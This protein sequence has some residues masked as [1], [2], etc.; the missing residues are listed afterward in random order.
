MVTGA[1]GLLDWQFYVGF[2]AD[3]RAQGIIDEPT[4]ARHYV[5]Q[6]RFQGRLARPVRILL[7]YVACGVCRR[8][9][10]YGPPIPTLS[11][12]EAKEGLA[13]QVP[14]H[15]DG[16]VRENWESGWHAGGL[17]NQLYSHIPALALARALGAEIVLYPFR[18][19]ES[20]SSSDLNL[21][22]PASYLFDVEGMVAYWAKQGMVVHQ[23]LRTAALPLAA[24]G[25]CQCWHE[26]A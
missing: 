8:F 18:S 5:E 6:G 10:I 19:R 2:H 7:R 13:C 22:A 24:R 4:A 17:C 21:Y 3:L 14:A 20:F 11:T 15:E 12:A 26:Q 16:H 9:C 23:V 1:H 25:S